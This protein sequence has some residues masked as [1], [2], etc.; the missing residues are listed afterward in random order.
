MFKR[1][2]VLCAAAAS[3]ALFAPSHGQAQSVYLLAGGA[4]P[5]SEF[6]D[7]FDTGWMAAGGIQLP[8]GPGGLWFG[9]E[10]SYGQN[11]TA[12]DGVDANPIGA[13][14]KLGLDIP[15][16]GGLNPYVFIGGGLLALK[17]TVGDVSDTVSKFGYQAGGGFDLGS[18]LISPFIEVRYEGSEDIDFFGAS[19]GLSI[20]L[21]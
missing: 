21:N 5:T 15:I 11:G 10:G 14:A 8:L 20:G 19:V 18:G 3:L 6:G 13:M 12:V 17:A 16:P 1:A 4:F 9:V 2:I 7:A